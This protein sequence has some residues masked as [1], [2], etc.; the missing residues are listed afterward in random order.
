MV[1]IE[2]CKEILKQFDENEI[3]IE[4]IKV[5]RSLLTGWAR[6]EIEIDENQKV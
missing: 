3:T 2:K 4:E 1:S 5:L 6:I